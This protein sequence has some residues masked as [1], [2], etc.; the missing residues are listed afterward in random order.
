MAVA[1]LTVTS[2]M[3]TVIMF[4][5]MAVVLIV[6]LTV[7]IIITAAVMNDRHAVIP[8]DWTIVAIIGNDGA[9]LID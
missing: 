9:S 2:I 3:A 7:M 6:V 5:T 4:V 8:V 1:G